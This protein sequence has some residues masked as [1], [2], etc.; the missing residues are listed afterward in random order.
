MT[1]IPTHSASSDFFI[2]S[3]PILSGPPRLIFLIL[4][5]AYG[6]GVVGYII[7]FFLLSFAP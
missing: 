4:E 6:N 7:P 1:L 5:Y 2:S 3:H